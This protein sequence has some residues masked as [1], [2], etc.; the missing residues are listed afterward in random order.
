MLNHFD[1]IPIAALQ[2]WLF[3]PR[4]YGLIHLDRIWQ[5]NQFTV[6]GRLL[7]ERPDSGLG[8]KRPGIK[9]M[10]A[11][12]VSSKVHGFAGIADVVELHGGMP[13]PVEYKRGKPK[14]HR[15]DEVQLCAQTLCLEEMFNCTIAEGALFYG[16]TR[17]RK[18][19]AIDK[20]LRAL[21]QAIAQEV[22]ASRQSGFIPLPVYET[23]RCDRCS[24]I[25][26]CQPRILSKKRKI[27]AWLSQA[28]A[29]EEA[30]ES[31]GN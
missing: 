30:P 23:S 24:L 31:E 15:A 14:D 1:E 26:H 21:T 7:H 22:R 16:K 25:S 3:C 20:D 5:E 4:Q 28:I 10:R 13:Y 27:A 29:R 12:E 8:E 6:E 17:R 11:V 19:I 2:H 18:L 9:I